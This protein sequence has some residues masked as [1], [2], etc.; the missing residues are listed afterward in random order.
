MAI[1]AFSATNLAP[2]QL[3]GFNR[4]VVVEASA[5][6]PP[7]NSAAV[8]FNPGEGNSYYQTGLSGKSYGL[9]Q[10]R[11]FTNSND[12]AAFQFQSYTANNV[13]D[14]NSATGTNGTLTL[15][16]PQ[17]FSRIGIIANSA[18]GD[19]IGTARVTL[20]FNDGSTF[21]TNYY[22]PDWFGNG[23][24]ATYSVAL[25]G[26][27]RI[28]LSSG[29]TSG[30]PNDPRFYETQLPVYSMLSSNKPLVSLD[31]YIAEGS[32]SGVAGATGIY[33]ISGLSTSAI[34]LA[35]VTNSAATGL[36]ATRATL[37]G[38]IVSTGGEPPL[39]TLYYG[40]ANGGSNAN[41]WS[42]SVVLGYQT[43][44]FSQT[45][46]GL[47]PAR[48]YYFTA[49]AVNSA[50]T[51]WATPSLSFTTI[52]VGLPSVTNLPAANLQ[53]SAA[54]LRGQVLS[55][56]GD[57]P[58][59]TIFYGQTDGG[60]NSTSWDK[61]VALGIQD[62]SFAQ[63][64]PGLSS[65]TTN[66]YTARAVNAAGT[67][68]ASPS[69]F[70]STLVS[71]QPSATTA[72]LTHHNDLARLG[73]NSL[74]TALTPANVN[75]NSF[76]RLF[77]Y[78][79]DGYVYGQPLV[80]TN[81]SV[82]GHGTRNVLY[83]VTEHDTVYAFD[84]DGASNTPYWTNS[85]INPSAGV[86]TMPSSD[87][88]SG[89]LVP[90]IGITSTPV[91]DPVSG[92][93]YVEAKTKEVSG[94]VTNYVHRLH[95]LDVATGVEKFSGPK[96]IAV[97]GYDGSTYTYVSGPS[98]TG[99]GDGSVGG[100]V[101]FNALRQMN[102]PGLVLL[103]GIVYIAFAS[104][105]DNGPYHGWLLGYNAQTLA[106]VSTYNS[107]PNGGDAGFW[108]GAG[109]PA[110]DTA[111][112][113][114][115]LTGNGT[116]DAT[117]STFNPATND[118]GTSVLKFSTTNGLKLVDYFTPYN[119]DV[120]ST[121]DQDLGSGAAIVLPNSAGSLAHPHLLI[122]A[123][124]GGENNIPD[125]GK[126]YLLDRDNMGHYQSTSDSQIVQVLTNAFTPT[127]GS[128][129][130]PAFFNNTLYYLGKNDPLKAF[131]LSNGLILPNPV[132]GSTTFGHPGA[133]PSISA[134]GNF[135]AIVWVIQA[136][137]Y[138]SSG[139]AVLRA[140]NATNVAQELYNSSQLLSRDN[141]GAAVKF[142]VPTV[143]NG[144]V[145]VGAEYAVSSFGLAPY[146]APPMISP[147]GGTF[148]TN[149]V[150]VTLTNGTSGATIRYTL[151]N[152]LP[153]SNSTL[154]SS[155]FTLTNDVTVIATAFKNGY[156]T[157]P[158]A[159]ASFTLRS[160]PAFQS[161]TFSTNGAAQL[162]FS[163]EAG[164]TYILKVSTNLLQW[165]P[166]TTNVPITDVF[167]FIDPSATSNSV[168]FYRAVELP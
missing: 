41:N 115:C 132:L 78:A 158:A 85:F 121:Y 10:A 32:L 76:M 148:F 146:L 57:A 168:R 138:G 50:G 95:A 40:P 13:L 53:P 61:S 153:T 45:V 70:F 127:G 135:D 101:T 82:P 9:P 167:T 79:V 96:T 143:V 112:N 128:Y 150:K 68:W 126:I 111:S 51:V 136:D 23:N 130:T 87:S 139:P 154:Y 56:G 17:T 49:K 11:M 27:E 29:G 54:T 66:Y 64:L 71:N 129:G 3:N 16:T 74:E 28:A 106:L 39:V 25:Q 73:V 72:M 2:I 69:A 93:L 33:A 97:T 52:A 122:A 80:L 63:I 164:K 14:L 99:T 161:V 166:L 4:D 142:T 21:T 15:V 123:G 90:E 107:V 55:D 48:N 108:D 6:G 43:G 141:P 119:Q 149:S 60:T 22:A 110:S 65:S 133:T 30:A 31:F 109:A 58:F 42:N 134:D 5:S 165:T 140:Y 77:S 125:Q 159:G 160:Y 8:E 67:A 94:S 113:L 151:D 102:R 100:V 84:A 118:F 163:G 114:Y 35:S 86:T 137:A 124:K 105:S 34:G 38:S 75:T 46:F 152:T 19:S 44:P 1:S 98:V 20:H 103:N 88:L 59:V 147:N 24:T 12:G 18:N 47:S 91:I 37:N 92:T 145:Y 117:G 116:F 26:V 62:G 155:P 89:D 120:L 162:L 7:Y 157:S 83:I 131:S 156:V 81:V 144:K 104:H 36:Q